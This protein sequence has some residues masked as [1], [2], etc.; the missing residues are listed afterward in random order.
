MTRKQVIARFCA[1]Q[2]EVAHGAIGH[3]TPNDCFCLNP[4]EG[5]LHERFETEGLW[6][7]EGKAL[8]WIERVV[9]AELNRLEVAVGDTPSPKRG[10]EMK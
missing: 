6:R 9:R 10:E 5:G 1:L 3:S 7:S 2:A 4:A 8:E